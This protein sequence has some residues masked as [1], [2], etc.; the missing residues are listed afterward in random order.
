VESSV[1]DVAMMTTEIDDV[2]ARDKRFGV[3]FQMDT[4]SNTTK[5]CLPDMSLLGAD[6]RDDLMFDPSTLSLDHPS[7][8]VGNKQ[9]SGSTD[10]FNFRDYSMRLVAQVCERSIL[11]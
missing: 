3:D 5:P 9:R 11:I 8:L 7:L 10:F 6:Y 2:V 1:C 4:G